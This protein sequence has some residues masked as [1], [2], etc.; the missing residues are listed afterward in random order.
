MGYISRR[1]SD[2]SGEVLEDKDVVTVVVRSEG[3]VFDAAAS[4][5][6]G[7]K[8]ITNVVQLEFRHANGETETVLCTKGDFEKV[9]SP[10]VL[11]NADSIRGRRSGY[12]PTAKAAQ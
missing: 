3:K 12:K 9:V 10:E 5:L 1:V 11:A 7:L 6:A 4:E 8:A 2:L